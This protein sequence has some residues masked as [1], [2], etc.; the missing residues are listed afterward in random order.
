MASCWALGEQM[1]LVIRDRHPV[2][3]L[4]QALVVSARSSHEPEAEYALSTLLAIVNLRPPVIAVDQMSELVKECLSNMDNQRVTYRSPWS[5]ATYQHGGT[6]R[7]N[8]Q[9][10]CQGYRSGHGQPR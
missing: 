10:S 5:Y 7:R 6:E 1:H 8:R 2:P 9:N 3:Q 4:V